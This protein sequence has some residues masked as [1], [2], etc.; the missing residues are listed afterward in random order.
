MPRIAKEDLLDVRL[1]PSPGFPQEGGSVSDGVACRGGLLK[2]HAWHD[3]EVRPTPQ[4]NPPVDGL[5]RPD[6]GPISI[7]SDARRLGY[8]AVYGI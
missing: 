2:E 4:G 5:P 6:G 1:D 3:A 7:G 8:I